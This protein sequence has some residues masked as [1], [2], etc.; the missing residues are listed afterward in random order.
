M[1]A[2]DDDETKTTRHAVPPEAEDED[3][4]ALPQPG[5]VIA[6]KYRIE[7]VI[8]RGGMG[9]VYAAHHELLR[10]RVAL[11][12]VTSGI[13]DED[14]RARFMQEARASF[15]IKNEHVA[16]ALDVDFLDSGKPYMVLEYLEGHDLAAILYQRGVPFD[17]PAAVDYVLQALDALD[18]AHALG[19][20][21]RDLKPANLFVLDTPGQRGKVKV[22]DFGIAKATRRADAAGEELTVTKVMLG[23]PAYMAPEQI[24]SARSVDGRSDLWAIGVILYE[25]L[26]R[27]RPFTGDRSEVYAAVLDREPPPLLSVAPNVPPV[28]AAIVHR[29][30]RRNPAE[31]FATA[32][33]LAKALAP[34]ASIAVDTKNTVRGGATSTPPRAARSSPHVIPLTIAATATVLTMAAIGFAVFPRSRAPVPTTPSAT[35]VVTAGDPTTDPVPAPTLAVPEPAAS[36]SAA[37]VVRRRPPPPKPF[38][39]TAGRRF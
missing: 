32:G 8:G 20:I 31:R 28:L 18:A 14:A 15:Q 37:P 22:L 7:R 25:L 26:S 24:R 5:D 11:K 39:P 19:I 10:E 27:R 12:V 33:E 17:P 36:V 3:P 2:V 6:N 16:R 4:N 30:L 34:F 29:C 38:D 23:T 9:V 13:E 1:R 21:H 35:P